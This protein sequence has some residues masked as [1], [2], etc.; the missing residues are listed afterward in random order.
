MI[1]ARRMKFV[2]LTTNQTLMFVSVLEVSGDLF[3]ERQKQLWKGDIPKMPGT[4]KTARIVPDRQ[5][6]ERSRM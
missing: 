3:G 1:L 5:G 6:Y 4:D 2:L